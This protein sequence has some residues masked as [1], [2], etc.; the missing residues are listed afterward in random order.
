MSLA[1]VTM[2][3]VTRKL[4]ESTIYSSAVYCDG[5]SMNKSWM[6]SESMSTAT[7]SGDDFIAV[8]K[9]MAEL[10][11]KVTIL[12]A[13]PTSI[14]PPEKEEMLNSAISQADVLEQELAATK[15]ALDDSLDPQVDLVA[16]KEEEEDEERKKASWRVREIEMVD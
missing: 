7:I 3:R 15:K 13:Q 2:I 8:M 10:E 12:S 16:Y 6:Q 4:T 5:N 14:M 1:I 11:Q 9:R